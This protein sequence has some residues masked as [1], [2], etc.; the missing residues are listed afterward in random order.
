MLKNLY[1]ISLLVLSLP[2]LAL[3][4]LTSFPENIHQPLEVGVAVELQRLDMINEKEHSFHAELVLHLRWKDPRLAFDMKQAGTWR[5]EYRGHDAKQF[6]ETIWT[7][8]V[9]FS[10]LISSV[11]SDEKRNVFIHPDGLVESLQAVQ[12]TFESEFNT[13]YFPFDNQK[14]KLDLQSRYYD[15]RLLKLVHRMEDGEYSGISD[16]KLSQWNIY[17]HRYSSYL[18]RGWNNAAYSGLEMDIYIVRKT[19]Q[20]LPFIF[21]PFITL[22]LFP[23][24]SMFS[25][26]YTLEAKVSLL[27]NGILAQ[28]A[29]AFTIKSTYTT[30]EFV[31]NTVIYIFILG[32]VYYLITLLHNVLLLNMIENRKE[33]AL[34][35]NNYT[36]W[37]FPLIFLILLVHLSIEAIITGLA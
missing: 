17:H 19:S 29:L 10:N 32:I 13:R 9:Y 20:F 37:S 28:I 11:E 33:L 23:T 36:K 6:L 14:L 34:T 30:V 15:L 5:K 7:P 27:L 21:F 3:A 35:I 8:K 16:M 24:I 1:I 4:Q 26:E 31:G 18:F 2:S 12:G 25:R 22:M